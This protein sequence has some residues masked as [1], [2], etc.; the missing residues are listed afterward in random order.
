MSSSSS[1]YRDLRD[2]QIAIERDINAAGSPA[3]RR[4]L[5][6]VLAGVHNEIFVIWNR[7][8]LRRALARTLG[9]IQFDT[10]VSTEYESLIRY[11]VD[12]MEQPDELADELITDKV[13]RSKTIQA[14]NQSTEDFLNQLD[15]DDRLAEEINI[16]VDIL[17]DARIER[18]LTSG[19]SEADRFNMI[20]DLRRASPEVIKRLQFRLQLPITGKP[21]DLVEQ[22]NQPDTLGLV[23]ARLGHYQL[24]KRAIEL[25]A[26][27]I[28]EI[29]IETTTPLNVEALT[30]G[31]PLYDANAEDRKRIAA[32]AFD[33]IDE[34]S[35]DYALVD[36]GDYFNVVKIGEDGEQM[37]LGAYVF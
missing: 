11:L 19:T 7:Y 12:E 26:N 9:L 5:S 15:S 22:L 18:K 3:E 14:L 23:A 36:Q 27:N 37:I 6:S 1:T 8:R 34:G 2:R 32:D 24:F 33:M 31:S 17:L 21:D 25:G 28:G 20:K 10:K 35:E 29:L 16:K 13:A 4:H 30:F